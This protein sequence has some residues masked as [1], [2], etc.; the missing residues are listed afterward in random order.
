MKSGSKKKR[1][2]KYQARNVEK[3]VLKSSQRNY[4]TDNAGRIAMMMEIRKIRGKYKDHVLFVDDVMIDWLGTYRALSMGDGALDGFVKDGVAVVH[5]RWLHEIVGE[6][7]ARKFWQNGL[8]INHGVEV[9]KIGC[10]IHDSR[11]KRR[12]PAHAR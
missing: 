6:D 12:V 5:K 10:A 8:R 9:R 7:M 11:R 3:G 1:N 4:P 2:K